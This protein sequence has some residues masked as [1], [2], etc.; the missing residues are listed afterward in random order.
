MQQVQVEASMNRIGEIAR[1][2]ITSTGS[3]SLFGELMPA[4][5][6]RAVAPLQEAA[7]GA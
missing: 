3:H 5:R 7:G 4:G 1:V 2:Q 6:P